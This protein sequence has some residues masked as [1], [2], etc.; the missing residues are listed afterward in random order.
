M[1]PEVQEEVPQRRPGVA[2]EVAAAALM[3]KA[4]QAPPV[5][6]AA[7]IMRVSV[8][9][10]LTVGPDQMAVAVAVG[11]TQAAPLEP[12]V[13][14]EIGT[15]RTVLAAA[16]AAPATTKAGMVHGAVETMAAA[17]V[18]LPRIP[19]RRAQLARRVLS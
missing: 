1:V 9:A 6:S 18:E 8:A 3:D 2:A 15:S 12:E 7:T 11:R 19:T 5:E 16:G 10:P 17:A 14:A 4:S 13:P